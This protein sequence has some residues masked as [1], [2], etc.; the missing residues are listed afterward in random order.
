VDQLD[1][2]DQLVPLVVQVPQELVVQQALAVH[3]VQV[4]A[5]TYNLLYQ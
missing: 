4:A 2:Q 3:L 1:L 5:A